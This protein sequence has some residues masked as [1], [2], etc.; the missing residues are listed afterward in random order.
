MPTNRHLK[1]FAFILL[2]TVHPSIS[3]AAQFKCIRVHDGD[4]FKVT[5]SGNEITVRLV[6]IDAPETSKKKLEPGQTRC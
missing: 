5:G 2:L 3:L 1:F 4:T 6:G